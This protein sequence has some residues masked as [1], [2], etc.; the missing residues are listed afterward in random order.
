MTAKREIK[1]GKQ[2]Q[3]VEEEVAYTLTTTPWG[4]T[5]TSITAKVFSVPS[6]GVDSDYTDTTTD[7]FPTNSPSASGD[8][9]TLSP[10]KSLVLDT[11]YR[12][13]VK[14]TA[15]GNIFEAYAYVKAER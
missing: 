5:P 14:F 8:I 4:S 10:L 11:L 2:Y 7:N 15:S 12:V 1:E 3:G 9:I 13:E 6:N